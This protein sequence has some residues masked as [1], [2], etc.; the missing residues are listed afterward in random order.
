[1]QTCECFWLSLH[2]LN[3]RPTANFPPASNSFFTISPFSGKIS[4]ISDSEKVSFGAVT[5]SIYNLSPSFIIIV[6]ISLESLPILESLPA[7]STDLN[8]YVPVFLNI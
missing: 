7:K 5:C 4:A 1:M 6:V 8:L 2:T 3:A